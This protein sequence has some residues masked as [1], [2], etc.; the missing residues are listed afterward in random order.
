VTSSPAGDG[1][2]LLTWRKI[3]ERQLTAQNPGSVSIVAMVE[4]VWVMDRAYRLAAR[5]IAAMV[6][7]TL[8]A[9][10]F[11]EKKRTG[12][13]HGHDCAQERAPFLCCHHLCPRSQGGMFVPLQVRQTGFASSWLQTP[14]LEA[15]MLHEPVLAQNDW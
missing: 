4:T 8:Q 13:F 5:K 7:R 12:G 14:F 6:E 11:V 9:D 15:T 1:N 3:I 10:A 2:L